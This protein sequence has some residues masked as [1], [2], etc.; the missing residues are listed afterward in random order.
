MSKKLT[1]VPTRVHTRKIDRA[2]AKNN[3]LK[4]GMNQIFKHDYSR[5]GNGETFVIPSYFAK[6]WREYV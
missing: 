2:V 6:H 3:M 4:A 5:Y 1:S